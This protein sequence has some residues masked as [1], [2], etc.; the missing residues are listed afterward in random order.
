MSN[1]ERVNKT[2]LEKHLYG[3]KTSRETMLLGNTDTKKL[4]FL[5][6]CYPN[7]IF[8]RVGVQDCNLRAIPE[9][10]WNS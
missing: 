5:M 3:Q 7:S 1:E 10:K 9:A 8:D 2:N 4:L 6:F